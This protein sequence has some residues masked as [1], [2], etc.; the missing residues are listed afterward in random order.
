[1][2]IPERRREVE[3]REPFKSVLSVMLLFG[4]DLRLINLGCL[5]DGGVGMPAPQHSQH[6]FHCSSFQ[7]ILCLADRLKRMLFRFWM[8]DLF[9]VAD[10]KFFG[11]LDP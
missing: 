9:A 4:F 8:W 5:I 6:A 2:S 7:L 10:L 11:T 3:W 1:M